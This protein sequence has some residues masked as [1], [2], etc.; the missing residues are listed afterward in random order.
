MPHQL[1]QAL[2]VLRGLGSRVL[3]ADDVGLGKTIQAA[4]V[5][6]ELKARGTCDRVLI[7]TPAGLREQWIAELASRFAIEAALVD[8]RDL[9]RRRA[10]LPIGVNPWSTIATAF[11]AAPIFLT[12]STA[13][14]AAFLASSRPIGAP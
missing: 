14:A 4:M 5:L 9:R 8:S 7:L 6:S 11:G 3:I 2:A 12:S 10:D 13:A 1:E